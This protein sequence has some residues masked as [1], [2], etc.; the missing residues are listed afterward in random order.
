MLKG[1]FMPDLT[2]AT[3]SSLHCFILNN[4]SDS[5]VTEES[6]ELKGQGET[7][8]Y[9]YTFMIFRRFLVYCIVIQQI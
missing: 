7:P 3:P 5:E 9:G 2:Q 4:A 8:F 6:E 1:D